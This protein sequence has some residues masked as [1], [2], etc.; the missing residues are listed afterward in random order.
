MFRNTL[1]SPLADT[2]VVEH[3]A[4]DLIPISHLELDLPAPVEGW[5]A[6]LSSRDIAI[7]EDSI[8]RSAVA[9]ADARMLISE[10]REAE[11]RRAE[12]RAAAEKRAIEDDARFRARLGRGCRFLK[13]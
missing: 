2:D 11:A 13:V 12:Q 10:Q 7:V 6:Y 8:G 9:S 1:P 4:D 5:S 3:P